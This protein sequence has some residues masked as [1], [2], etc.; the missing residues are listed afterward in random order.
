[1]KSNITKMITM[2]MCMM[3]VGFAAEEKHS[4]HAEKEL[5]TI[6]AQQQAIDAKDANYSIQKKLNEI[7]K[8]HKADS[9]KVQKRLN[10][11]QK[12]NKAID[13]QKAK[14]RE[15][16][17]QSVLGQN[18]N[19]DKPGSL[20][21]DT[22]NTNTEAIGFTI[23]NRDEIEVYFCSDSWGYEQSWQIYGDFS[24]GSEY[25]DGNYGTWFN[26]GCHS[27]IVYLDAGDYTISF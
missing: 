16:Y 25:W 1:M 20:I 7:Q 22:E 27:E 26:N 14:K 6:P 12:A 3:V 2:C 24:W 21:G 5:Q 9:Y 11:I 19:I 10:E 15:T 23:T 13:Y 4:I 8:A 17:S 18:L